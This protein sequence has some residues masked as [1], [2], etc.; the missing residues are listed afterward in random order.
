[1]GKVFISYS[2][3]DEK[4]KDRVVKHLGVL[5]KE[6]QLAVWHDR[7]IAA[8]DDWLPA[9]ERAIQECDT[10]LLLISVDFLNSRF[11]LG[12][13]VPELLKR[14][15]KEGIRVIPVIISDCQWTK[16][17][18]L[19]GIQARP[20]NGIPLSSVSKP[21]AETALSALAAEVLQLTSVSSA[22]APLS[23]AEQMTRETD[24]TRPIIHS[25]YTDVGP[26]TLSAVLNAPSHQPRA[27]AYPTGFAGPHVIFDLYNQSEGD[28]AVY[29]I[30]A[31]VISHHR[32][33]VQILQHGVGATAVKRRYLV[34]VRPEL[35][36][37]RAVYVG[38]TDPDQYVKLLPRETELVD[39][40]VTT[41][42]EGLY[43]FCVHIIGTAFGRSFDVPIDF[44]QKPIAF[45]DRSKNYPVDRGHGG[46]YMLYSDYIS[47]MST[48]NADLSKY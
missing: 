4:W 6:K 18:W 12:R 39:L 13:E 41:R 25:G 16:V 17:A 19:S 26:L 3:K 38:R 45:F 33:D 34:Q 5:E 44:T 9:I 36:R 30:E 21:K 46:D 14:R 28:F 47:E 15:V 48:Y 42:T 37:Y 11:I 31:E 22:L 29:T 20:E 23:P 27:E 43:T 35:G 8:G 10:A 24:R 7:Q 32:I 1:M 2:H 40:E